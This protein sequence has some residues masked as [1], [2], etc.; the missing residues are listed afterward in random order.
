MKGCPGAGLPIPALYEWFQ[1]ILH[2][3]FKG[4]EGLAELLLWL[5]VFASILLTGFVCLSV[6]MRY[7]VRT[8]FP[9]S[10][11]LVALLFLATVFMSFPFAT[12]F[13]RHIRISI[14]TDLFK[15]PGRRLGAILNHAVIVAFTV[16]FGLLSIDYTSFSYQL[17]V[18]AEISGWTLWPWM[19]IMPAA[20]GVTAVTAV[21]MLLRALVTGRDVL[22]ADSPEI[23]LTKTDG[24]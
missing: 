16:W 6:F 18:K 19:A 7:F 11:E 10:E 3:V 12:V 8:P 4:L 21:A 20:F 13:D 9:F 5:G 1:P 2:L 23:D 15:A 22:E 14:F 24:V 17:D